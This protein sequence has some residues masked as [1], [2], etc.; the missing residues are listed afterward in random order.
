MKHSTPKKRSCGKSRV[1]CRLCGT[2]RGMISKY[3]LNLCRR[4]FR[5]FAL[6]IGFRQYQ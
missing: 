6:H 2:T 4:C 1:K 3:K 5:Q